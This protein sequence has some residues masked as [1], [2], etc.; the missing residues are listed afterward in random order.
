MSD[1]FAS[2]GVESS[3]K[4]RIE[5]L[6]ELRGL[7]VF[8]VLISHYFQLSN[9]LWF[10]VFS[11]GAIFVDLFFVISGFLIGKI[12][13]ESRGQPFYFQR[14]YVRRAFRILPLYL[15]VVLLGIAIACARNPN[16]FRSAPFYLTFTQNWLFDPYRP[17]DNLVGDQYV[18][19]PGLGPLWSLAV[20]EQF[21]FVM[22]LLVACFSRR[23][24]PWLLGAMAITG[25]LLD[26]QAALP[27]EPIENA[28]W[29]YW[30]Y[31]S[32]SRLTQFK[33]HFLAMGVLFNFPQ[34]W[35]FFLATLFIG[36]GLIVWTEKWYLALT[37]LIILALLI[38]LE[39]AIYRQRCIRQKQLAWC[40]L[41][42]FGVYVI[43]M[44]ILIAFR[45]IW[46][47]LALA[48]WGEL[49]GFVCFTIIC[50]MVATISFYGFELPIQ[51]RRKRFESNV[52]KND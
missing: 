43:H 42:C 5:G 1:P 31:Y 17:M 4:Q 14:F 9:T 41:L 32:Y 35:W 25:I 37:W 10:R 40:G 26:F 2:L 52:S 49:L 18:P 6:D 48:A 13:I 15:V 21:Y 34:R 36:L 30:V 51:R 50:L 3:I 7:G 8:A 39:L 12:L 38:V 27:P 29:L 47:R 46:N 45:S 44:P 22:P 33:L 28:P 11:P 20:E 24:L 23:L 16:Y 19:I